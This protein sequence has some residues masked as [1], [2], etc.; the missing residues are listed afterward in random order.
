MGRLI[1]WVLVLV[2]V[3]LFGIAI[4]AVLGD[5][6]APEEDLVIPVTIDVD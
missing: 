5:L 6:S 2:L 1:K 4:Y 3:G